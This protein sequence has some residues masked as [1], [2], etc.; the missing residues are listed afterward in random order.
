M[1]YGYNFST[2]ELKHVK[3]DSVAVKCAGTAVKV[4]DLVDGKVEINTDSWQA[5]EYNLQYFFEDEVIG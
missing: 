2:I 3:A 1:L 5:T 4:Y